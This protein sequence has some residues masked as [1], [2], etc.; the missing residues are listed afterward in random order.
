MSYV[1][2]ENASLNGKNLIIKQYFYEFWKAIYFLITSEFIGLHH[3][4]VELG[5]V[6]KV[7]PG[8]SLGPVHTGYNDYEIEA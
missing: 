7:K 5:E 1:S 3:R 2:Q 4:I 8:V 6:I